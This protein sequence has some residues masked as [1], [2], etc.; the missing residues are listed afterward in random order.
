MA[1]QK[2]ELDID[3]LWQEYSENP[4]VKVM[5]RLI[6]H[7]LWLVKFVLQNMQIPKNQVLEDKDYISFGIL[8]L[9]NAIERFEIERGNKFESYAISRIRG[10]IQDELRRLDW[11]SRSARKKVQDMI[12]AGDSIRSTEGRE[13]TQIE[14]ME[15][16]NLTAEQFEKYL[17]AA[18][19]AKIAS[20]L[21]NPYLS[22][23]TEEYDINN[24]N[25]LPDPSHENA[26]TRIEH[27]ER[28]KMV[29]EYLKS[30]KEKKR[31]VVTLYYYESL[32]FKEIGKV[33]SISESRACQIHTQ[34]IHT[35]REKMNVYDNS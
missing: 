33:L 22:S 23:F 3:S 10:T 28:L 35:L 34:V 14:I 12:Y 5:H 1:I 11:L 16:L 15:K 24:I 20:S 27:D 8:G 32:S 13:A 4:N 19:S 30:L 29:F 26:L 2:V 25:E 6:M 17:N 21:N 31:L 7:Y 18:D 9:Q